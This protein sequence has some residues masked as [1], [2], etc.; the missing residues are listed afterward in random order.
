MLSLSKHGQPFDKLRANGGYIYFWVLPK[1]LKVSKNLFQPVGTLAHFS[2]L[3][4]IMSDTLI[5]QPN[6]G[7]NFI[8]RPE[9]EDT[10]DQ[11][12]FMFDIGNVLIDF[13]L[14]ILQQR[15]VSAS[16]TTLPELQHNWFGNLIAVE[17][18]KINPRIFYEDFSTSL[19]LSWSYD[20]WITAWSEIYSIH[21]F[22]HSLFLELCRS[23]HRVVILSNL[24]P[25]NVTAI[26]QK[27]PNFFSVAQDNFFSFELGLHKPD[28]AIYETVCQ[29]LRVEPAQCILL[30]DNGDNVKG[31]QS[32]GM[33]AYQFLPANYKNISNNIQLLLKF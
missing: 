26:E 28:P 3:L 6:I 9:C 5:L 22:G 31:A 24:A 29:A 13:D 25:Y 30:D 10:M 11:P 18:G 14:S 19:G 21:Q 33:L 1:V 15:I 17:T 8:K 20:E 32:V 12:V 16:A 4:F 23:G 7:I 27:F 2:S